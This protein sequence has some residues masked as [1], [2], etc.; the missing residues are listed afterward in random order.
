MRGVIFT[1]FFLFLLL[2]VFS[3]T[4]CILVTINSI[5]STKGVVRYALYNE[6]NEYNSH[7]DIFKEGLVEVHGSTVRILIKGVPDGTYAISVLHDENNNGDLDMSAVGIPKE[8]F[9]FS[10]DA[11]VT[12]GPPKFESAKF[13]K[14]GE[15]AIRVKMRYML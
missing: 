11:K 6:K 9:G 5:R 13:V 2:P 14:K 15:T 3:Q 10:N 1:G 4:D 7:T 8:G 12:F